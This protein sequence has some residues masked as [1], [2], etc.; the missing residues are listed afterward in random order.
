MQKKYRK[1]LNGFN[2]AISIG[3]KHN[4]RLELSRAYFET[5]KFL[6]DPKVKYKELNGHPAAYYLDKAKAMFE[7][8]ELQWD[9]EAYGKFVDSQKS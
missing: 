1:A 9:L 3:E 8:M 5:G 4:S 7:E 2:L 6:S